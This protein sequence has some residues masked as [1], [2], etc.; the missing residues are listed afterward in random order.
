[1]R[2]RAFQAFLGLMVILTFWLYITPAL[3][4]EEETTVGDIEDDIIFLSGSI[5]GFFVQGLAAAVYDA[6]V[7]NDIDPK[8]ILAL[9]K[10]ESNFRTDAIGRLGE[11]GLMQVHGVALNFRPRHCT[12]QL[13]TIDCQVTTGV[14]WL[15]W[16]RDHCGGSTWRWVAGYG[17]SR[18]PSEREAR[19]QFAVR[20][21][22]MYYDQIGGTQ[23][24]D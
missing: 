2:S 8:L 7:E 13:R 5:Y 3:P 9:I 24:E 20:Q 4:D 22:R 18:C 11:R 19:R 6:A 17:M 16:V 14:R 10:R 15:A 12:R 23:W 21:A 1:M